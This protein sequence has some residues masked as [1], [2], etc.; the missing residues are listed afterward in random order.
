MVDKKETPLFEEERGEMNPV[1][2]EFT[3]VIR[4]LERKKD[5]E[6]AREVLS[7]P[8]FEFDLEDIEAQIQKG[9]ITISALSEAQ[10]TLIVQRLKD[11]Q[12]DIRFDLSLKILPKF[13]KNIPPNL[14]ENGGNLADLKKKLSQKFDPNFIVSTS[15]Q[16][17]DAKIKKYL[18]IVTAEKILSEKQKTDDAIDPLI[19]ELI[20]KAK[21]KGATAIIGVNFDFKPYTNEKKLAFASATAVVIET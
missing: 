4:D 18:G 7:L 3:L 16:L 8:K 19:H 12:A 14:P 10:G 13:E 17:P 1:Y 20:L 21:N 2:P 11:I 6:R 15:S 5:I 9:T